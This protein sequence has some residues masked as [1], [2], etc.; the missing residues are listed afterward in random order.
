MRLR[1]FALTALTLYPLS[2]HAGDDG[3][4]YKVYVT[5]QADNSLSVI[6]GTTRK[7]TKLIRLNADTARRDP[8]HGDHTSDPV[9]DHQMMTDYGPHHVTVS[10]EWCGGRHDALRGG[11][12]N[13]PC[14][15]GPRWLFTSNI[16]SGSV[17]VIDEETGNTKWVIPSGSQTHGLILTPDQRQLW[18]AN[19]GRSV[20]VIDLTTRAVQQIDVPF[21]TTW[22][23]FSKDQGTAYV[24]G[25]SCEGGDGENETKNCTYRVAEIDVAERKLGKIVEATKGGATSPAEPG[26]EQEFALENDHHIVSIVHGKDGDRIRLSEIDTYAHGV[27]KSR[28]GQH[29]YVT[30]PKENHVVVVDTSSGAILTKISVSDN[31]HIPAISPDGRYVWVVCRKAN[32]VDIIDTVTWKKVDQVP[33]GKRPHGIAI[34]PI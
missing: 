32:V 6:D 34:E 29:A 12:S 20:G 14:G 11:M 24:N 13:L 21:S 17:S 28:D 8:G 7:I 4:N 18:V 16:V 26:A 33:V 23:M 9:M 30:V 2:A 5:N 3:K 1:L 22:V 27:V 19:K 25:K 15:Q 10:R 31:P